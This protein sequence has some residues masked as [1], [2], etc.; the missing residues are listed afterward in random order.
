[1]EVDKEPEFERVRHEGPKLVDLGLS[2]RKRKRDPSDTGLVPEGAADAKKQ[3]K[4]IPNVPHSEGGNPPSKL[5]ASSLDRLESK[6]QQIASLP[7]TDEIRKVVDSFFGDGW[8]SREMK[9]LVRDIMKEVGYMGTFLLKL[10]RNGVEQVAEYCIKKY[11]MD[12][13]D[14]EQEHSK[15]LADVLEMAWEVYS[16]SSAD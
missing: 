11:I 5:S 13:R 2:N 16:E 15:L 4:P 14:S 7:K 10:G 6:R 9:G 8:E 1:M 12:G 3:N